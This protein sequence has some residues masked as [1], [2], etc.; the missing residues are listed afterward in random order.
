MLIL[1]VNAAETPSGLEGSTGA[2]D[3]ANRLPA[4]LSQR[5]PIEIRR[6]MIKSFSLWENLMRT[7]A[8]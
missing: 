2:I 5:R 4:T 3:V 8:V 1:A 7:E 6:A